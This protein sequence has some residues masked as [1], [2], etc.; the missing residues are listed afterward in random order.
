MLLGI[1]GKELDG[2]WVVQSGIERGVAAPIANRNLVAFEKAP[3]GARDRILNCIDDLARTLELRYTVEL[4][5][6]AAE[7]FAQLVLDANAIDSEA[8]VRA[9]SA[10]QA[11]VEHDCGNIPSRLPTVG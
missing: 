10:G 9:S 4:D 11:S 7:A 2:R 6:D 3:Q 5:V 8:V 1:V